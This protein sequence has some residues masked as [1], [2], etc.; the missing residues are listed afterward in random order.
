MCYDIDQER[1]LS[2]LFCLKLGN[3]ICITMDNAHKRQHTQHWHVGRIFWV[4]TH[5]HTHTHTH[6]K[7]AR[8]QTHSLT[9]TPPHT[10]AETLTHTHTHAHTHTH[11]HKASQLLWKQEC[12][13][14]SLER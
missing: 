5:T 1:R 3:K 2:T 9:H 7:H 4:H 14:V 11:T 10:E 12:L 6:K 13:E 8:T